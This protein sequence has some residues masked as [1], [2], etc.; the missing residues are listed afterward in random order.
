MSSVPRGHRIKATASLTEAAQSALGSEEAAC[1]QSQHT[2]W[3]PDVALKTLKPNEN[4]EMALFYTKGNK[5][6]RC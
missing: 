1:V 6:T 5:R 4:V 3:V 2:P